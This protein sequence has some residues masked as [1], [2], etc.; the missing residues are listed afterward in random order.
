VTVSAIVFGRGRMPTRPAWSKFS[1][2][3]LALL[4]PAFAVS[5]GYMDPGN[6]ATDLAA[7]VYGYR[8]LWSIFLASTIAIVLQVAVSRVTVAHGKSLG[9]L[10]LE[11]WPR[12]KLAFWLVFEGAAIATDL[13]EFGGVVIGIQL[14]FRCSMMVAVAAGLLAMA[15]L[16][17]ITSRRTKGLEYL[18]MGSVG[19][20]G[21]AFS[22]ETVMLH[23]IVG[24]LIHGASIPALPDANAIVIVVGIIGA[25]VMPHNLFLHSSLIL[26]STRTLPI[27]EA[28]K[29]G[30]FF[31]RETVVALSGAALVNAAILVVGAALHGRTSIDDAFSALLPAAGGLA[32]MFGIALLVS[33]LASSATATVCGDY[34][35][36]T[37]GTVRLGTGTRR[38]LTIL[39]A[40][41]ALGAGVNATQLLIW[42][43]VA[44]AF[45]LPAVL[46]P[47]VAIMLRTAF[48]EGKRSS[49]VLIGASITMAAVCIG[50][51]AVAFI[52]CL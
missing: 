10:I 19:I 7:G 44:L 43:Q 34:I 49:R 3:R 4:G 40:A 31:S 18:L 22:Y 17:S 46:V 9:A 41:V 39:P 47:L 50:F 12:A 38:A 20:I 32:L 28:R 5:I 25:T 45:A 13:A 6:W 15:L 36:E 2:P 33:G 51:D 48:V 29:T 14:I 26:N 35:S 1:I 52:Q 30:T 23:P 37:F 16:F 27:E 42:S 24:D 11:R 8:L 21:L